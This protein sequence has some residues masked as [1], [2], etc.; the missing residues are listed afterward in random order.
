[1]LLMKVLSKWLLICCC[2]CSNAYGQ[3]NPPITDSTNDKTC[4]PSCTCSKGTQTPQGVMTDHIHAKG[5][6]MLSYTYMNMMM[7]GNNTGTAHVSDNDVYRQYMMAP[8]TM[9]MQ[10]H[11]AMVMYGVTDKLT[12]MA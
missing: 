11:M 10:M 6:W 4:G 7:Q 2:L 3:Q 1:M 9:S 5:E 8:A 12:L